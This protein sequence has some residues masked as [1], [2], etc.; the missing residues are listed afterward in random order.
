MLSRTAD[1]LFWFSRY[2]ERAENTAR[3]LEAAGRLS[4]LPTHYAGS[5]NE[6]ES[7]LSATGA[8]HQYY[9]THEAATA[10]DVVSFLAFD[11]G[12]PSSIKSCVQAARANARAVRTALTV[13]MWVRLR[14]R[15][16]YN[17]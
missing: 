10:D 4:A 14:D 9:L 1:S 11:E 5:T 7:A 13:E 8:L 16:H 17:I 12:N 3:L 6:W 15:D 2:I